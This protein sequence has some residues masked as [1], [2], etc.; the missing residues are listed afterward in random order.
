MLPMAAAVPYR[1]SVSRNARAA[2]VEP[3][4][5]SLMPSTSPRPAPRLAARD[6][7]LQPVAAAIALG[8]A[9]VVNSGYAG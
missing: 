4:S 3:G 7:R 2:I 9:G 5:P 8:I 6:R 1:E